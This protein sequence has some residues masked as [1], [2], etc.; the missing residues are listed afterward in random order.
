M[1]TTLMGVMST[2]SFLEFCS[3]AGATS[4]EYQRQV[5]GLEDFAE[6]N[7]LALQVDTPSTVEATM[8]SY[9]NHL[10]QQGVHVNVA[11]KTVAG[12]MYQNPSYSR[13]GSSTIPRVWKCLRGW[14]KLIPPRS[15]E[16]QKLAVW[17]SLMYW[18][19][20]QG[21]RNMAIFV[22]VCLACYF[23]PGECFQLMV[24][25]FLW[26]A[27]QPARSACI[28]L[29]PSTRDRT[30]KTGEQD[31]GV[32]L[33]T[34]WLG[35]L[36]EVL[37]E[38]VKMKTG[39]MWD[40]AYQGFYAIFEEGVTTLGLGKLVPYQLRHSGAAIDAYGRCRSQEEIRR[41]GHWKALKSVAR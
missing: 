32:F 24:E 33:D 4:S 5:K 38:H 34:T 36:P 41:R 17:A 35:F 27:G 28:M 9:F 25:D 13:H 31:N 2:M 23:R 12:W 18:M 7:G 14:R 39:R 26:T 29:F 30:N 22:A 16:P 40:F 20:S 3:V 37:R 1:A 19:V 15:R 6:Q 11:E 8:V 21:Y 10:F